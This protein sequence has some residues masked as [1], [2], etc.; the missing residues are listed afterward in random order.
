MLPKKTKYAIKALIALRQT[1]EDKVPKR[2][3]DIAQEEKIPKKFLESILLEMRKAG[4]VNSRMGLQGGYYLAKNP[5]E[6]RLSQVIRLTD[7]PI[8][9]VPCASLNYYEPCADCPDEATCR[10]RKIMIEVRE[11]SLLI[12][13]KNTLADLY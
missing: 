5:S 6:I 9:L 11:A 13:E 1:Y 3:I 12:L 2:I 7:G 8:A 10:L 4:I